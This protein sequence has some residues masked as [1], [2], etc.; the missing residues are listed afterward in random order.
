MNTKPSILSLRARGT[1][2]GLAN[3]VL[4]GLLGLSSALGQSSATFK[5]QLKHD[6]DKAEYNTL[7]K[8]TDNIALMAYS[9]YKGF[10]YIRTFSI[11]SDGSTIDQLG[12]LKFD[13]EDARMIDVEQIAS[14]IFVVAYTGRSDDGFITTIKVS[15]DGSTIQRVQ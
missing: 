5:K 9:G 13:D 14:D 11:A 8:I 4:I 6:D 3:L 7:F 15:A 2:S 10:G 12:E 1:R